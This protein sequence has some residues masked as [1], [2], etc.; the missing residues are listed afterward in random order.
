MFRHNSRQC[1]R[2]ISYAKRHSSADSVF[3][4]G[5]TVLLKNLKHETAKED[6]L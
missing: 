4:V 5:D 2:K 1:V 3:K 6:G